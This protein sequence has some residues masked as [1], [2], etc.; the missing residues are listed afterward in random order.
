MPGS[1]PG[2][3]FVEPSS[4]PDTI[5]APA[6]AAGRAAIAVFRLSGPRRRRRSWRWPA[7][8]RRRG[9]RAVVGWSTPR[10]GEPLDD[11]LVAVVSGAGELHRRGC[12]RTACAWQP[13]RARRGHGCAGRAGAAARRARRIHPPRLSQR[14]ARPDPGRG[15]RRPRRGRDRGAA[16]PGVAPA[17]RRTGRPLSR[18][19]A[20]ADPHSRASRS[21]DRFSRRGSAARDRDA[22]LLEIRALAGE[23]GR[24]LADGRRGERLRDGIMVAIVGPPNAGKSSLL[25]RIARREAAITSP[26]AG[27]TRD[28]VEV[29]ID[30][31]GYPVDLRRHRRAARQRRPGRAGR[32]APRAAGAPRTPKSGSSSSTPAIPPML[33]APPPGPAPTRSSS[34]TKS[35]WSPQAAGCRRRRSRSR[36]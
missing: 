15:G 5:F 2:A 14:Q 23:I 34:P 35:T 28:I 26:I 1:S 11:A 25:N 6:T 8:C 4:T 13:R 18:L 31:A 12:R 29:A 16:P 30:L 33:P 19:G 22:C 32:P 10:R 9:R 20:A 7:V 36:R 24:H 21:G 27:T 3:E 17:R